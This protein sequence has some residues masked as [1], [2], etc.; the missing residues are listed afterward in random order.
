[1]KIEWLYFKQILD[2]K[3]ISPQYTENDQFYLLS[4]YESGVLLGECWIDKSS[5]LED[6]L[7]FE[8]NYKPSS[9]GPLVSNVSG[10]MV[11]STNNS[12]SIGNSTDTPLG[13]NASFS[14]VGEDVLGFGT[15]IVCVY[16]D[17]AGSFAVEWSNDNVNWYTDGDIYVTS[18]GVL[19]KTTYGPGARYF[20]VVYT[21]GSSAQSTFFV[22]TLLKQATKSSSHKISEAIND[23]ADAELSLSVIT[24]KKSDN[25][26]GNAQLTNTNDLKTADILNSGL[27]VNGALTV[28]TTAVEAKVGSS[29]LT[30]R[31]FL[32]VYNASI[33]TIYWGFSNAVTTANGL[34]ITPG[35]QASWDVGSAQQVFL[36][37]GVAGNAT[38]VA[39][40]S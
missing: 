32:T 37:A 10:V 2:S 13:S 31:K 33:V 18:P 27:G 38:R 22:Q 35:Q 14:G 17:V 24:G 34:P 25:T 40:G 15:L 28:G 36:I 1:M 30:N 21:N 29:T 5:Q 39:E 16:A 12:I 4:A 3:S 8:T 7:D 6:A 19:N 9:N 11:S 23:S 26:Y 20:R